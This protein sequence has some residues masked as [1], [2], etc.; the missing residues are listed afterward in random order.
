MLLLLLL[1]NI[2]ITIHQTEKLIGWAKSARAHK[3]NK[4]THADKLQWLRAV[5]SAIS[6]LWLRGSCSWIV[7]EFSATVPREREREMVEMGAMNVPP[8]GD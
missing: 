8:L 6:Y 1:I 2:D 7:V 5:N 4:H 3:Y